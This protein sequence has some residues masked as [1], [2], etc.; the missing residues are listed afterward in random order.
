[1]ISVEAGKLNIPSTG[2]SDASG[3]FADRAV[4]RVGSAS[5]HFG[6]GAVGG[7]LLDK[8]V[9][10]ERCEMG[11]NVGDGRQSGRGR[12]GVTHTAEITVLGVPRAGHGG[13]VVI[14]VGVLVRWESRGRVE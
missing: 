3:S 2:H 5:A 6:L 7:S 12:G 1:M 11:W 8:S 10:F 9:L 14:T 13:V 4:L